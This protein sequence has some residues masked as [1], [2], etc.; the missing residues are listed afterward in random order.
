ML[1]PIGPGPGGS[2][3]PH[4]ASRGKGETG[5]AR[6]LLSCT[7]QNRVMIWIDAHAHPPAMAASIS[8]ARAYQYTPSLNPPAIL[9]FRNLSNT[10]RCDLPNLA[11]TT[12][13][14]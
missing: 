12:S 10:T 11:A 9:R 3:A 1:P 5:R 14:G 2:V 6:R 4:L 7:G 13:D 8:D